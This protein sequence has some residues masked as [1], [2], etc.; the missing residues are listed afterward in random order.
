MNI[1]VKIFNEIIGNLNLAIYDKRIAYY[2]QVGFT[3]G[4]Q[5]YHHVK[6][7]SCNNI[8]TNRMKERNL[9]DHLSRCIKSI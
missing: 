7:D 9:H 2:D 6:N 5:D 8:H 3:T 1:D 4:M